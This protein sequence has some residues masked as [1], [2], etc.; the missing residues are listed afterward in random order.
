M[1]AQEILTAIIS[2]GGALGTIA[3]MILNLRVQ[4][5]M[6]E[7][8]TEFAKDM[9]GL[10]SELAQIRIDSANERAQ[11]AND[12]ASTYQ[13]LMDSIS[14]MYVPREAQAEMH[15]ANLQRLEDLSHQVRELATKVGDIS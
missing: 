13:S 12:R 3:L 7:M 11:A 14:R 1:N 8:R 15:R 6:A 4:T 9:A 5:A 10:Q 2:I